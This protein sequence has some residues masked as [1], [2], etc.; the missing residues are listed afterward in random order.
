MSRF[1]GIGSIGDVGRAALTVRSTAGRTVLPGNLAADI[2]LGLGVGLT[3]ALMWS[4]LPS[5]AR[6]DGVGAMGLALLAA[7]PFAA[8]VLAIFAGRLGPHTP[9]GLALVRALGGIALVALVLD[10]GT[11]AMAL[12]ALGFWLS[13][14]FG[15]PLQ[16]RLWGQMYPQ[17][18]RGRLVGIVGTGRAAA[19][20][21]GILVG[22]LLAD[23][24]GGLPVIAMGGLLGVALGSAALAVRTSGAGPAT[25]YSVRQSLRALSSRPV[26]ARATLAQ[27]FLGGG[28]ICAGPLLAFVQVDRLSLSLAEVGM[29]GILAALATTSSY[30]AFGLLIDRRGGVVTMRLGAAFGVLGLLVYALAPSLQVLLLA[31]VCLG[32][33]SAAVEMGVQGVIAEQTPLDE[34]SAAMAG[35]NALT[36]LRGMVAPFLATGLL[37]L[38]LVDVTGGLLLAAAVSCVGL[39]IFLRMGTGRARP[40]SREA[41]PA[42]AGARLA[43]LPRRLAH[44]VTR[45]LAGT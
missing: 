10:P 40:G 2:S 1:R 18:V 39:A 28:L 43:R 19:A 33:S 41:E 24:I 22:G 7:A 35:W 27:G 26:L 34:R 15:A 12:I 30:V 4:L 13:I 31:A 21:L 42:S 5:V 23:R 32:L 3:T 9:R 44:D 45:R 29:L 14:S 25:S 11:P 36:G 17:A 38:G 37:A 20:G 8:N 6:R 16:S